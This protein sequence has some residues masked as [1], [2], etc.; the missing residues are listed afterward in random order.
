MAFNGRFVV[1]IAHHAANYGVEVEELIHISGKSESELCDETCVV[2]NSV[3]SHV[4]DK[5]VALSGDTFFGLHAGE[6]LNNAAA[7]LI[8]QITQ[9]CSTVKQALEY[10]CEFANLGCSTLPMSLQEEKSYYKVLINPQ[11]NF[12]Q[13]FPLAF[14]HT[15]DGVLAFTIKE[16]Q[17]L[18]RQKHR[19][20]AVYLPWEEPFKSEEYDRVF[21]CPVFY[22]KKEIAL[23]LD[24]KDV[25]DKVISSDYSLLRVLVAHAE[26]KNAS[27]LKKA[28]FASLVKQSVV[29]LVKP[30]FP[31]IEMVAGHLNISKRTLQRKLSE[32]NF[33]FKIIIDELRKD[34]ALSYL[35]QADLTIAEIA[36]LLSYSDASSFTRSF[37]RWLGKS[38]KV[39]RATLK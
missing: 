13:E 38:P 21:D 24:K 10:C 9:S 15:T 29:K 23:L 34:F 6:N 5:A 35:K 17:S 8:A 7:G 12:A 4:I 18:T 28:G 2:D 30:E 14:R 39:Y 26:E 16:F 25:E 20:I 32:E 33:T 27:Y 37:K 19:P 1:N 11:G 31:T 22:N 36:Y 3:Y